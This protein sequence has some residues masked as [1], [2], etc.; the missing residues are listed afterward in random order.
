MGLHSHS[1]RYN[2]AAR[3]LTHPRPGR[4]V[5]DGGVAAVFG[6]V[7]GGEGAGDR[8]DVGDQK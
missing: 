5:V 1:T 4:L 7:G 6:G 3:L 2:W 8:L